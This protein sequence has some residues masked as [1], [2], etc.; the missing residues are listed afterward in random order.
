MRKVKNMLHDLEQQ[1]KQASLT[2]EPEK[3]MDFQNQYINLKKVEKHLSEQLG[4]RA[5]I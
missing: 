3:V 1:I 4:N 2:N 5:I